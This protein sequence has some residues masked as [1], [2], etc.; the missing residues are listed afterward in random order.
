MAHRW[1]PPWKPSGGFR[2]LPH[3]RWGHLPRVAWG[4]RL[5]ESQLRTTLRGH[6]SSTSRIR[7]CWG[8]GCRYLL[9][10]FP[11]YHS[12]I[13]VSPE[14]T[15]PWNFC[16][17][18]FLRVDLQGTHS[19]MVSLI[20]FPE[21]RAWGGLGCRWFIREVTLGIKSE[22]AEG[23]NRKERKVNKRCIIELVMAVGPWGLISLGMSE[24][25]VLRECG[26][27][28]SHQIMGSWGHLSI[29]YCSQLKDCP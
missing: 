15:P 16:T 5:A 26:S 23:W 25:H 21:S 2:E 12:L 19:K 6:L 14:V 17:Q 20:G 27:D 9:S 4:Q 7:T 8:F 22:G 3:P 11:L 10:Q 24:E 28:L 13:G 1:A 18:L 29:Y